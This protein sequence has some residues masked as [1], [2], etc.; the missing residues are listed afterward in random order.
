MSLHHSEETHQLLVSRVPAATGRP[1]HEWF[2]RLEDGPGFLRFDE[3]VQWLRDEFGI[4]HGHATAIVH[5][6][7]LQ[8]AQRSFH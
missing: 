5:E 3:R 2:G 4:A 1:L 7:D 8:K 6:H